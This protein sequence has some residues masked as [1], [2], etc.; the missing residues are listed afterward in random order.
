MAMQN[1]NKYNGNAYDE[2]LKFHLFTAAAST[3]NMWTPAYATKKV[4]LTD[5]I[6]SAKNAS[7]VTLLFGNT[8]TITHLMLANNGGAVCNL[9]TSA[10]ATST[11]T[12]LKVTVSAGTVS[13]SLFGYEE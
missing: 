13:I 11:N 8:S 9:V 5:F 4:V 7:D 3:Y 1:W 2:K 12:P 6:V 10:E